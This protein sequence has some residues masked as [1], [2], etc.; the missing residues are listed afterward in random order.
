MF[1]F[2]EEALKGKMQAVICH[3]YFLKVFLQN[4]VSGIAGGT[5]RDLLVVGGVSHAETD[6]PGSLLRR[7]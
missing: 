2:Q 3:A 6:L 7:R 1:W 5:L 4:I